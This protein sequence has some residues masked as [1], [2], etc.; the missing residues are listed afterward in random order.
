MKYRQSV[1]KRSP[2]WL[3]GYRKKIYGVPLGEKQEGMGHESV[4]GREMKQKRVRK[5]VKKS[6]GGFRCWSTSREESGERRRGVGLGFSVGKRDLCG[7]KTGLFPLIWGSSCTPASSPGLHAL[8]YP[9]I[10]ADRKTAF[11]RCLRVLRFP[12]TFPFPSSPYFSPSS[13]SLPYNNRDTGSLWSKVKY[14]I[15]FHSLSRLLSCHLPTSS[16]PSSSPLVFLPYQ[17]SC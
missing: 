7:C 5:R 14:I 2:W 17:E 9:D 1:F 6:N 16:H 11:P 4:T 10:Y 3:E 12:A 8:N 15:D 13:S